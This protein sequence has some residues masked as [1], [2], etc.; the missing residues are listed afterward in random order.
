MITIYE[1]MH[2]NGSWLR[3]VYLVPTLFLDFNSRRQPGV[4]RSFIG[5]ALHR[6]ALTKSRTLQDKYFKK[7]NDH[8]TSGGTKRTSLQKLPHILLC[9]HAY[10]LRQLWS[11]RAHST[12]VAALCITQDRIRPDVW[13]LR[14]EFKQSTPSSLLVCLRGLC[15][16]FKTLYHRVY[17]ELLVVGFAQFV[18]VTHSWVPR[19]FVRFEIF[20]LL[21][22]NSWFQ[23]Q[24]EGL[25]CEATNTVVAPLTAAALNSR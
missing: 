4:P 23:T 13:S 5:F 25:I 8:Q 18:F 21:Q 1:D 15:T 24:T 10:N 20:S 16:H 11:Q 17:A 2:K 9:T 7:V 14:P 19:H 6:A 3:A 12:R 22:P